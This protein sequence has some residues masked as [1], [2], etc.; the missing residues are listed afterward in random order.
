MSYIGRGKIVQ[1]ICMIHS[2]RVPAFSSMVISWLRLINISNEKADISTAS[3]YSYYSR[4]SILSKLF[5]VIINLF[6]W[7]FEN[8]ICFCDASNYKKCWFCHNFSSET[9]QNHYTLFSLK[10]HSNLS[11]LVLIHCGCCHL[12]HS[13]LWCLL[14]FTIL[15]AITMWTCGSNLKNYFI[16]VIRPNKRFNL[17][18][19]LKL[20]LTCHVF[21]FRDF[22]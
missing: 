10:W 14:L 5:Y 2:S 20:G 6:F 11:T 17:K 18:K 12:Q 9:C 21:L 1:K 22:L 4:R 13:S 19:I 15:I 16:I 3:S 7:Y 8:I